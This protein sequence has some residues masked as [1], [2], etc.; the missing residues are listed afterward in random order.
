MISKFLPQTGELLQCHLLMVNCRSEA[1]L[2]WS[3]FFELVRKQR[4]LD[5]S[6]STIQEQ[7]VRDV[8]GLDLQE[9]SLDS[10]NK[11]SRHTFS[12]RSFKT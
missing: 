9:L 10:A 3:E 1:L 4:T 11:E 7:E 12:L 8:V 2:I 6:V 5:S